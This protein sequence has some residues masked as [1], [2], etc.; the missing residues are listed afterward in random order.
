MKFQFSKLWKWTVL[1]FSW[2]KNLITSHFN[3][4]MNWRFED[5]YLV[6]DFKFKNAIWYKVGNYKS[7][8]F[9][10]PLILNL[11]NIQGDNIIFE[12]FGFFRKEVIKIDLQKVA[13]LETYDFKTS[14][15][16]INL[17]QN[18]KSEVITNIPKLVGNLPLPYVLTKP[19][20]VNIQN[21]KINI[22]DFK[23]QDYI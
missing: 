22:Q 17:I 3:Y 9:K 5:C 14:L 11:Q 2:K 7:V 21:I 4:F 16:Q 8:N 12:V 10:N 23:Q 1:L 19:T 18:R 20:T 13:K 15:H 6:I